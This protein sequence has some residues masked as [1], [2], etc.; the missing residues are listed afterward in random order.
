MNVDRASVDRDDVSQPLVTCENTN[1]HVLDRPESK[2][3]PFVVISFS[4]LEQVPWDSASAFLGQ[5]QE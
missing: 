2:T 5:V 1:Y 3:I 4:V